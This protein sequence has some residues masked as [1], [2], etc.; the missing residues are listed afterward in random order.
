MDFVHLYPKFLD[1]L[2]PNIRK[3]KVEY[4]ECQLRDLRTKKHGFGHSVRHRHGDT[5]TIKNMGNGDTT[6]TY[7]CKI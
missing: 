6:D 4:V 3:G 5:P 2:L 1:F 7:I